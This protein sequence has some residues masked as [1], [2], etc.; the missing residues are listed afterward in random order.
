MCTKKF[1]KVFGLLLVVVLLAAALPTGQ[2]QAATVVTTEADLLTA[3]ANPDVTTIEL[4][5]H[6][7]LTSTVVVNRT[8]SID[9]KNF[10][11]YGP[12]KG[13]EPHQGHGLSVY[14][15]GVY[16]SNLTI[17]GSGRSNLNFYEATGGVVNNVVLS[18]AANAGM[19][20]KGSTVT[21]T[22][23]T[24]SGN[25]WGGINVDQG[26][27]VTATPLLTVTNVTNHTSHLG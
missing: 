1:F 26:V 12:P 3:L 8:V 7:T 2:A 27:D 5:A 15:D 23:V 18:S 6:I 4:G 20:V 17:T 16:I 19:I 13:T 9:G 14:A 21:I 24:T 10:T 11:I 25:A 22:N